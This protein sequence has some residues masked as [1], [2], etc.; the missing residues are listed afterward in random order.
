MSPIEAKLA[1][2][3]IAKSP[4]WKGFGEISYGGS[5]IQDEN[6]SQLEKKQGL[7][8]MKEVRKI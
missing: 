4:L 2:E 8:L 7:E 5:F 3:I 6:C 1:M